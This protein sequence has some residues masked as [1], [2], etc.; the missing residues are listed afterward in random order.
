MEAI[1]LFSPTLDFPI[2]EIRMVDRASGITWCLKPWVC[3]KD[4]PGKVEISSSQGSRT[5]FLSGIRFHLR[6]SYF[7]IFF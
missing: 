4:T 5:H 7:M 2:L 6:K 3:G 1:Q